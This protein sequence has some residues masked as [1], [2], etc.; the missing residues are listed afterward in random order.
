MKR[1]GK[2]EEGRLE[3]RGK[4]ERKGACREKREKDRKKDNCRRARPREMGALEAPG[5]SGII[6]GD[7]G[8]A[9]NGSARRKRSGGHGCVGHPHFPKSNIGPQSYIVWTNC[10]LKKVP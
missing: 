2:R 1:H 5:V 10:D 3:A 7:E 8:S 6:K 9:I 4:L